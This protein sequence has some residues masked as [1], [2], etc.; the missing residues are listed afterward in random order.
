[1]AI[2]GRETA[3]DPAR[4]TLINVNALGDPVPSARFMGGRELDAV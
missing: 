2:G 1:M 4:D 3:L